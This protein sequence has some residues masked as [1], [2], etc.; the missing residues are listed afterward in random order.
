[1]IPRLDYAPTGTMPRNEEEM[2][3]LLL[4]TALEGR[5]VVFL[6]N[7]T[8]RLASPSLEG[9]ITSSTYTGRVL[10]HSKTM[11]CPKNTVVFITGNNLTLNGD[12]ARR[13]MIAEL[14][15][16]GD[17]G[18]RLIENHLDE[19]R[20]RGLRPQTLAALYALVREWGKRANPAR[21]SSTRTSRCGRAR[22]AG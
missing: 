9:F 15:L 8:G 4:A 12:M 11:V 16:A 2:R 19:N 20:L 22:S 7:V 17:P 6:D 21:T 10:N 14:Y 3:K 13:T 1:M 5:A 18:E